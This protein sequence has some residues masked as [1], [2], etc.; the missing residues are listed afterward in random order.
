MNPVSPSP[1]LTIGPRV[2]KSPFYDATV[3]AGAKAFTI[4][5]HMFMPTSYGDTTAEYWAIV[6]GV[7]LWDVAAERQIEISGP[8]AVA[9]T[10]LLTPR[11]IESCGVN[12]CR[13]VIFLD[14]DAGI[15]NDA[16]LYR[17]EENRFWLS[18]GDSDVLLWAKGIASMSGMDVTVR[19]PDASP[20][21]LQGPLAPRVAKKLFGDIAIEM[22]YFHCHELSLDGIPVVLSRT[23]WS[24]ELGYEIILLDGSRGTELWDRCMAAGAEFDIQAACPSLARSTE[25]A[26]LSY[27]SDITMRDNP[28]TIGMDRLLNIDKPHNYVGK[29]ALQAIAAKGTERRLVGANF[30]GDPVRPNEHFMDIRCGDDVVGHVT[31]YVFSPRLEH[32]I[33]LVNLPTALAEPGTRITIDCGDEWREAE[34]VAIP[35]F[36]SEKV[37]PAF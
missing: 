27:A 26:L 29:A 30:G 16:V 34:V 32:N 14:D 11:D 33:A 3:K 22:G 7:S 23:G 8:D 36:E 18:P 24:G 19:E 37:I 13:Y 2:R 21:Q 20:L 4:Y 6:K 28:F 12:R 17:L 10:Q 15:I 9:F 5:N 25:G 35:W 31:R 1:L